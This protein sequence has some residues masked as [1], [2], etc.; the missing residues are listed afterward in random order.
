MKFV[1]L[2]G[3]SH[4]QD[5][6]VGDAKA[7]ALVNEALQIHEIRDVPFWNALLSLARTRAIPAS[8]RR[9]ALFHNSA[10]QRDWAFGVSE[11]LPSQIRQVADG[12]RDRQVLA[13]TSAVQCEDGI[14]RHLPLLDLRSKPTSENAAFVAS[15]LSD[16][17]FRG[18]LLT[19]GN[20]FHF[21]GRDLL[22][23]VEL[24]PFLGRALLCGPLVDTR[25]VGH[26]LIEGVCALRV[27]RRRTHNGKEPEV[28]AT[29]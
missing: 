26:Q 12:L 2:P 10:P 6:L 16:L 18:L 3:A 15:L 8:V 22:E 27:S 28:I 5:R 1:A 17:G 20:S 23:L 11:D 29:I 19:S 14:I 9:E 25:W 13:F 4:V 21:Y 24:G 7:M